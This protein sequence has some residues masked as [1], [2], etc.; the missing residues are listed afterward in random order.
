MG[1]GKINGMLLVL[2]ASAL[3]G[4]SGPFTK[5]LQANGADFLDILSWRYPIGLTALGI[6]WVTWHRGSSLVLE[7]RAFKLTCFAALVILVVNG[8]FI[9]SNF[10][11][12]VA[13]AIALSFT[14]PVFAAILGWLVLGEKIRSRHQFAILLGLAGV[15]L[16]AVHKTPAAREGIV[17]SSNI[18]LGNTLALLCGA[19]FGGYFVVARKFAMQYGEVINSTIWQFL[20][21][22]LAIAPVTVFTWWRGISGTNY[23]YLLV[24]GV[25]CTA[26]PMLL[27]NVAGLFLKA[28]ESSVVALSEVPFCIL[29][30]MMLVGEYPSLISWLSVALIVSAALLVGLRDG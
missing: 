24:Y 21:L 8:A 19:T 12:T 18:M 3:W 26:A 22:T 9:L 23:L 28:H 30:G 29:L 2:L 1:N 16:L 17:P 14:A 27:I 10:Y 5:L 25:F 7:R 11:T 13:N 6:Y 20:L 15:C 4:A